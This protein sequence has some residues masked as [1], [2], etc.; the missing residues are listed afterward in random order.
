MDIQALEKIANQLVAEGKGILAADESTPTAGKRLD[1]VGLDNSEKNRRDMREMFFTSEGIENYISGVILY[2]ET[3]RQNASNGVPF[4]EM[5]QDKGIIPGI[6]VDLGLEAITEGSVEMVT[7]G[8]DGLDKRLAEYYDLGARFAKWRAVYSITDSLPTE[9]CITEN[10]NRLAD[11]A[12]ACQNAG[13]VPIVEP[14]VL[15]DGE[16]NTHTI[17]RCYEVTVEVQKALFKALQEKNVALN[18]L[19]LKPSMV[20]QGAGCEVKASVEDVASNTLKCL[21]SAVPMNVAGVVFLSGGQ[22]DEDATDHLNAMNKLGGNDLPWPLTFSYGR[23]LQHSALLAWGNDKNIQ[24]GQEAFMER[25]KVNSLAAKGEL[26][27]F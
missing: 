12:L 19:L 9:N 24:A 16:H 10:A 13:I 6:K 7:K 25:A 20:I 26:V 14:E 27:A 22:N 21:I 11:Y 23:A 2:D 4:R 5:L 15:M 1:L 8:L 3:L 17:E 18:G